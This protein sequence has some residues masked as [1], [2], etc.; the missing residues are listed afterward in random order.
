M[1]I[2]CHIFGC[3]EHPSYPACYHCGAHI[4]DR[5]FVD[6]PILIVWWYRCWRYRLW[7]SRRSLLRRAAAWIRPARCEVCGRFL[8]SRRWDN[9]CS[10]RCFYLWVPF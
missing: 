9:C 6:R 8:V 10:K 2:L 5:E 4:Y 1:N 7:E 3:Q